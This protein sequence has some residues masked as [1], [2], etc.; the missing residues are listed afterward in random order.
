MSS[1]QWSEVVDII[2]GA[3]SSQAN[4]TEK[5]S[6]KTIQNH[7]PL[8]TSASNYLI[9]TLSILTNMVDVPPC[10]VGL[11]DESEA[12][13]IKAGDVSFEQDLMLYHVLFVPTLN[14]NLISVSQLIQDSRCTASF[15]NRLCILQDP[16]LK[17]VIGV[18][19]QRSGV[20]VLRVVR[21]F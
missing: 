11:P 3:K 2:N 21:T 6:G 19:K 14:Y 9:G 20:Y 17:I 18:G 8:D 15:A 7:W 1:K 12:I 5:L 10:P 13:A 16:I 4:A